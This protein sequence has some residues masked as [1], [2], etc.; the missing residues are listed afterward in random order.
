[1][2]A[3]WP[4]YFSMLYVFSYNS[5][6]L[7]SLPKCLPAGWA[8]APGCRQGLLLKVDGLSSSRSL[9]ESRCLRWAGWD[10]IPCGHPRSLFSVLLL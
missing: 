9:D 6:G 8:V 7:M 4:V 2:Q 10:L 5:A 3:P 1:M